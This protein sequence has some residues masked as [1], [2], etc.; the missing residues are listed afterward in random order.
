MPGKQDENKPN[1]IQ[2]ETH[3]ITTDSLINKMRSTERLLQIYDEKY[4]QAASR[5]HVILQ[6]EK[7]LINLIK[8]YIRVV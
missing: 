6:P 1:N 5:I 7:A 4:L 2:H 3:S 8:A